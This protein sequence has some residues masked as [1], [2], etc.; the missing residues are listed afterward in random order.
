MT[1]Q[2]AARGCGVKQN[3]QRA[4][5]HAESMLRSTPRVDRFVRACSR[6]L[7]TRT[8]DRQLAEQSS[9][10]IEAGMA[11][12]PEQGISQEPT[13]A[14]QL[15]KSVALVQ[16]E[17]VVVL[18]CRRHGPNQVQSRARGRAASRR[19]LVR[20]DQ[21][22]VGL[23]ACGE[24]RAGLCARR[25]AVPVHDGRHDSMFRAP[26]RRALELISAC[27]SRAGAEVYLGAVRRS[28]GRLSF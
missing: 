7:R 6:R 28:R 21:R 15:E 12:R 26:A 10:S 27:T 18:R 17:F 11:G 25:D 3:H 1:L 19:P 9:V 2:L 8:A 5:F 13:A 23:G 22:R 16:P 24:N 4:A 14:G 20:V